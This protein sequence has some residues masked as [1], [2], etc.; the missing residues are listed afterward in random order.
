M[1]YKMF[2]EFSSGLTGPIQAPKGELQRILDH[3][4]SVEESLGYE[5]EQYKDNPKRWKSTKPSDGVTNKVFCEVAEDHNR[6]V[7]RLFDAASDWHEKPP[8]DC[9]TI[10]PEDATKF[11]HGLRLIHVPPERWTGDYYRARMESLYDV[12]RGRESDGVTFNEKPL[13]PR[14]AA[15]VINLFSPFLDESDLRLDVPKGHDYLASSCDGG[16]VWCEKCGAVTSEHAEMCQKRKCPVR[17][18]EE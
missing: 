12:M 2:F 7:M 11:W 17:I 3:V 6:F 9:E 4:K 14:Q 15:Q 10:T 16:Y 8:A 5:T 13:T 1:S 18:D